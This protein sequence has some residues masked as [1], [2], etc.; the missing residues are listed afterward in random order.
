MEPLGAA[1]RFQ[2]RDWV[3]IA[4]FENK[5]GET[6]LDGTLEYALERELSNSPFV[7]VAPRERIEDVLQLMRPSTLS[8]P[9]N[10]SPL[11]PRFRQEQPM[12]NKLT[13]YRR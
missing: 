3:L 13:P 10:L 4:A 11:V 2:G 5:T 9:S 7:N 6:V 12:R 8:N 1:L